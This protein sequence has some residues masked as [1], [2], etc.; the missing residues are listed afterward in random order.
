ML[1]WEPL[2]KSI[3]D[4]EATASVQLGAEVTATEERLRDKTFN[5]LADSGWETYPLQREVWRL[6]S[7][8]LKL[9]QQWLDYAG[10]VSGAKAALA[11]RSAA[12]CLRS[13]RE[14]EKL[15]DSWRYKDLY[16]ELARK[17]SGPG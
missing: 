3:E 1:S 8:R 12:A 13:L 15:I 16:R 14:A 7:E 10:N 4:G 5:S 17:L 9:A 11:R 6:A 2:A